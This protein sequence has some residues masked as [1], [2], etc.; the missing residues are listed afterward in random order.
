MK[1]P[2][3]WNAQSWR[4]FL[5]KQHPTYSNQQ[6]LQEVEKELKSYPPLVFA[7]E[8][9]NLKKHFAQVQKGEAFL[10]QGG[11]CAESFCQFSGSSIRDLFKVIIQ[12]SAILTFA[13]SCPIVKVGRLAGQFAKPR[14]SDFEESNGK[15][16]PSYRGDIINGMD[17]DLDSR[18]PDATRMLKAY[19]QSAATLNLL[20]AFASGGLADLSEV[21][22][23]NLD[24]VRSNPFG[25][26]YEQ[27]ANQITQTLGFMNACGI[28]TQN[29]PALKETEFYTSHE[30]LLL[31]YEEQ[32]VRQDSLTGQW[33]DCSA[34]MLWIGE[35][36]RDLD[37]A[38]LE[39]LRGI[40]NP[41]GVKIGPTATKDEIMGI[42]EILNPSNEEGRLNLIVRMGADKIKQNFPKLLES[43]HKEG[44]HILWSCDPMHGNTIKANNG[45]KTRAFNDILSEVKS[46]FDI[47]KANGSVAGGIHLEMTGN[48]VTECVGGSQAITEANLASCYH[49]QCD[50]RLNA[51]QAIELAFLVADMLKERR[52]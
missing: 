42:C 48:D 45:Y 24:F 18:E 2:N 31:N 43:V 13:G 28:N 35:R 21:H 40:K 7:G 20:R 39:F 49:T 8:A 27:L 6:A 14:S 23:W 9:R 32:L 44:R 46:F 17:F 51:T 41:V 5:I 15:K 36:T 25:K 34:H 10:L 3:T 37:G 1:S 19:N 47:H 22:R 29:T 4:T 11:D 50:P 38:H 30:A 52:I 16:L 12:M 33:Y 26:K